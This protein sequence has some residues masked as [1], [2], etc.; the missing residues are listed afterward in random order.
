MAVG[1]RLRRAQIGA[2]AG[3]RAGPVGFLRDSRLQSAAIKG[4]EAVG[5][6]GA[7]VVGDEVPSGF[8]G[9]AG[10][11]GGGEAVQQGGVGFVGVQSVE[12]VEAGRGNGAGAGEFPADGDLVDCFAVVAEPDGG[13]EDFP[14]L[15]AG[16]QMRRAYLGSRSTGQM[17]SLMRWARTLRR[18][19]GRGCDK[20]AF[21]EVTLRGG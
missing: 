20:V 2:D 17:V 1:G 16:G 6:G 15:A 19:R 14:A 12:R 21:V 7:H 10:G 11:A 18:V 13:F 4:A 3:R 8:D 5:E 9:A